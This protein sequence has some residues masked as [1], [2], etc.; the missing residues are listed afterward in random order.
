MLNLKN[1]FLNHSNLLVIQYFFIFIIALTS[2]LMR[3]IDSLLNPIMYTEDGQ[4]LGMAFSDGWIHTIMHAKEG[5]FVWLNLIF[6]FVA[7]KI[8]YIIS[9]SQILYLP[10]T[11][12]LI[13]FSF[14]AFVPTFAFIV[15]KKI[16]NIKLRWL[17]FF[18]IIFVPMGDSS[19]EILGRLSNIGY[20]LVFLTML[21]LYIRTNVTSCYKILIIDLFLFLFFGTNPVVLVL[22]SLY[23][24]YEFFHKSNIKSFLFRSSSLF[25]FIIVFLLLF[26]SLESGNGSSVT[27]SLNMENI[28]EVGIA[29]S[30]LYPIIFSSYYNLNDF[31][32]I[33]MGT[34]L[35]GFIFYFLTLYMR[36]SLTQQLGDYSTTFPDRY[37]I[38]LNILV[39]FVIILSLQILI[40]KKQ[41]LAIGIGIYFVFYYI[42][43]LNW[44]IEYKEPRMNI[45]TNNNWEE[46]VCSTYFNKELSQKDYVALP[47][48]FQ[49]WSMIVS[50]KLIHNKVIKKVCSAEVNKYTIMNLTDSNW[51][52]GVSKNGLVLLLKNNYR[53]SKIKVP[54]KIKFSDGQIRKIVKINIVSDK[55]LHAYIDF[56]VFNL[57]TNIISIEEN[58]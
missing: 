34:V 7:E 42:L 26:L 41:T 54:I 14:F 5:Y 33:I 47:V 4:W 49:G 21:L 52:N 48:Y 25:V 16:L 35:F 27:G 15:T 12:S 18:L 3:N 22:V 50:Y 1:N 20:Y 11:I 2:L 32:S 36:Q 57:D 58:K 19:N 10:Y 38:G 17:L 37:F 24:V 44:L 51:I 46:T 8:S 28:I 40:T 30:I 56:P 45:M 9:G 53:N 29:R 23:L 13:S 31:I 6:L 55:Y 39:I 43:N